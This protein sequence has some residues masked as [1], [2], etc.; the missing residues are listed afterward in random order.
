MAWRIRAMKLEMEGREPL[1]VLFGLPI[2]IAAIVLGSMYL[3]RM[4]AEGNPPPAVYVEPKITVTPHITAEMP[5]GAVRNEIQVAPA[6]IHEVV[7]EIRA[8]DVNVVNKVEPTPVQV[9]MPKAT[10]PTPQ[11]VVI[12]APLP[13]P[14]NGAWTAA[15]HASESKLIQAQAPNPAPSPNVI[16]EALTT[17]P[18]AATVQAQSPPPPPPEPV[19]PTPV[20]TDA[21][22]ETDE[23]DGAGKLLPPPRNVNG[24]TPQK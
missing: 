14:M 8:P 18:T 2:V 10:G 20:S 12:P 4:Q 9:V 15:D 1:I 22:P 5:Q 24:T 3:G 23:A 16:K 13:L 6:Q 7:R 11:V 17:P 21:R 19:K